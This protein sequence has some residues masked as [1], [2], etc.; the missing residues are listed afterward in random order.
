MYTLQITYNYY[1][2]IKLKNNWYIYIT[3]RMTH[4]RKTPNF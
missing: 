2:K 1:K 4:V 3:L